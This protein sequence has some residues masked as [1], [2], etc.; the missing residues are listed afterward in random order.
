MPKWRHNYRSSRIKGVSFII[1]HFIGTAGGR[2]STFKK[3]R[4]S[5]GFIIR[6][7]ETLAHIDPGPGAFVNVFS[8][9]IKP[10][11]IDIFILSHIHLDH[12]ADIN[13]MIES[14]KVGSKDSKVAIGAP[15]DAFYGDSRVV[16]DFITKKADK[17]FVFK[18][19]NS[20]VWKDFKI[21]ILK[22]HTHHGAITYGLVFNDKIA[23]HPCAKFEPHTVEHYPKNI[24]LMIL[25]TTFYKPRPSIDHLCKDDAIEILNIVKPKKAIITHFATE[26]LEIGP[27]RVAKEIE[28]A[29]NIQ[30]TAASDNAKMLL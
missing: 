2:V 8:C 30:T 14:A 3:L 4:N 6:S 17:H 12:S 21:D 18:E 13:S 28:Q 15:E 7:G 19:N 23:Y 10:W 20:Y 27:E 25:N 1:I 9:G 29:T 22:R 11:D 26:M 24:D 5:G 16:L